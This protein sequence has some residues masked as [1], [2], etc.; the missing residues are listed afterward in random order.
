MTAHAS[1]CLND[2]TLLSDLG[3]LSAHNSFQG[4]VQV[5]ACPAIRHLEDCLRQNCRAI[6]LDVFPDETDDPIVRH[7]WCFGGFPWIEAMRRIRDLG[8]RNHD[9]PMLVFVDVRAGARTMDRAADQAR[10]VL[11][12]RLLVTHRLTGLTLGSMR[13]KVAFVAFP[14]VNGASRWNAC[15]S[16]SMYRSGFENRRDTDPVWDEIGDRRT[17]E[18]A[19]VYPR[20]VIRS[21]NFDPVPWIGRANFVALNWGRPKSRHLD[22]LRDLFDGSDGILPLSEL[23]RRAK[24]ITHKRATEREPKKDG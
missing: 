21:V 9:M 6:E 22:A 14:G 3:F 12:D 8:F 10:T 19:R 16:D 24:K 15:V 1:L 13:G 17:R 7:A 5:V 20:N 18:F 2:E 23:D 4:R 11:G